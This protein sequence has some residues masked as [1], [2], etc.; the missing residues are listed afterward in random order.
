[1][2]EIDF[3]VEESKILWETTGKK[4]VKGG[5]P[6]LHYFQDLAVN[7]RDTSRLHWDS[8]SNRVLV[9]NSFTLTATQHLM[10]YLICYLVSKPDME[11]QM[12]DII[13][14]ALPMC[15]QTEKTIFSCKDDSDKS[16]C[17][18]E[19]GKGLVKIQCL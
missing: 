3:Y 2:Y 11:F 5:Y 9:S 10:S 1:M 14:A 15:A 18:L 7:G 17:I 13:Y 12:I 16:V 8:G 4:S 19:W 6:A